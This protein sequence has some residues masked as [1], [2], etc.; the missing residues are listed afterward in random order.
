MLQKGGVEDAQSLEGYIDWA[1]STGVPEVRAT[2]VDCGAPLKAPFDVQICFKELYV[3]SSH[4]SVY[5][6]LSSNQWSRRH[7]VPMSLVL[8][9]ANKHGWGLESTLPWGAPVFKGEWKGREMR[10]AAYTEPS[11][12]WERT[13]GVCRSWNVMADGVCYASLED[14]NSIIDISRSHSSYI[15]G[16]HDRAAELRIN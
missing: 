7:Q 12:Y 15:R 5:H 14:R 9:F 16:D 3:S 13:N 4:E 10:V 1:A 8:D 6:D 11:V 2:L